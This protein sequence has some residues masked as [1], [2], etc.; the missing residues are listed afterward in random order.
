MIAEANVLEQ[1]RYRRLLEHIGQLERRVR[2]A[3]LLVQARDMEILR[4]RELFGG[5]CQHCDL[6]LA[7]HDCWTIEETLLEDLRRREPPAQAGPAA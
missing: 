1:H 6:L 7:E 3:T 4:L 2:E 5:R